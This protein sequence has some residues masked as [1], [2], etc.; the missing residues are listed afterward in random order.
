MFNL[1]FLT[2]LAPLIGFVLLA[3]GRKRVSENAAAV[4]GVGSV[5]I[6]AIV[7]AAIAFEFF[8]HPPVNGVYTQTL[9]TWMQVGTFAP[10]FALRLDGLSLTMMGVITGVGFFIHLFASWYMRGDEAFGRFFSYMNFFLAS[11]IF[12][13]L[14]DNLLFL[15]LGWEGVGLASYLLIGFWYTDVANGNAARKAFIVTRVGDTFLAIGM[16]LL[17][18]DL[19]T[20]DIQQLL[21]LA[22]QHY[23]PGTQT[24]TWIAF[25]I[26]GGACGKSAQ[27]PLQTWLPDAM[28][29]PT[30]V[31]ALIHAA[32]MVTA[33]VYLI[34]RTHVLFELAPLAQEW[35]G[36]IGAVT[37][38]VAGFTAL[39]QTDIKRVLAYSTMSQI[40]YMFLALG[41]GA[42]SAAVFHLMTHAFFKA[43]LFLSAGSVIL[44]CHH[45]QDMFRMGGLRKHI[46]FVFWVMVIG[47]LALTAM[48]PL[49]GYFSKDAILNQ[50]YANGHHG[51][52]LAGVFGAFLTAVYSFRL[53]FVTFFGPE[54]WRTPVA[55]A[56]D[57]DGHGHAEHHGMGPKD[58]PH[59][60]HRLD[61]SL[62]LIVLAILAVV[63][64]FIHPP[65]AAVLP[66]THVEAAEETPALIEHLPLIVSLLGVAL[67]WFLFLKTP[68][69]PAALKTN[70]ATAWLGRYWQSAF[71]FDWIYDKL[72]VKPFLWLVHLL[73]H[74]VFDVAISGVPLV[75]SGLNKLTARTQTG[76]LRWYAASVAFGA[77]VVIG[78]VAL[79]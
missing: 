16:F 49:S 19:G 14:G 45:E 79:S 11:M 9:W 47:I 30:P 61:H 39:M 20:L 28:A 24:I 26:L 50:A 77:V 42:W 33:G 34:A 74:D 40:G 67:S 17:F 21:T 60:A 13:V 3:F 65:L 71:G 6:S 56:H 52:W 62:P 68:S 12:L 48:P 69:I 72:L 38:L 59:G 54:R 73:R 41:A 25:L 55:V 46:P 31:S 43:L 5:G 66:L 22:P 37:L 7:T 15:F 75:L 4:I 44:A 64:G 58:E 63:G 36:I 1:L 70:P 23:Q 53:I 57:D 10:Q 35:V 2:F 78:V 76:Q 8:T 18:R 27:I 51:L 32:T 29:G